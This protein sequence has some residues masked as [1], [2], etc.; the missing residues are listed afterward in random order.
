[1]DVSIIGCGGVLSKH[2]SAWRK[3]KDKIVAVVDKDVRRAK[4]VAKSYSVPHVFP[5]L[6]ILLKNLDLI[7]LDVVDICTPPS[8]HHDLVIEALDGGIKNILVEKPLALNVSECK[9]IMDVADENETHVCVCHNYL[10]KKSVQKLMNLMDEGRL[11]HVKQIDIHHLQSDDIISTFPPW[12]NNLP[13]GV[14]G[15]SGPHT[16]YIMQ[17]LSEAFA[18]P[19]IDVLSKE[20]I[21]LRFKGDGICGNVTMLYGETPRTEWTINVYGSEITAHVDVCRDVLLLMDTRPTKSVSFVLSTIYDSLRLMV[22][23]TATAT[24]SILKRSVNDSHERLIRSYSES[25]KLKTDL[26]HC[27]L[28]DGKRVVEVID[29]IAD[30]MRDSVAY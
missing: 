29:A 12:V 5:N 26:P 23:T 17:A 22:G 24:S 20:H 3:T 6:G 16:I 9:E 25:C 27:S 14:F 18:Q 1:V 19:E 15:E 10:F 7:N 13:P 2:I 21:T 11:G 4:A 30:E 8:T 28:A